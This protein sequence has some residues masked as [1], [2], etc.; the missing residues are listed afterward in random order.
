MKRKKFPIWIII[1]ILLLLV[2]TG[3]MLVV[4]N[5]KEKKKNTGDVVVKD[6]V[7][8][9]TEDDD[10]EDALSDVS[11]NQLVFSRNP[12]YKKGDIIV[13]GIIDEAEDGFIR[14]VIDIEK[15]GGKYIIETEPAVLTDVFEKAHIV[16]KFRLTENGIEEDDTNEPQD[17]ATKN[18]DEFQKVSYDKTN[19]GTKYSI[20]NLSDTEG[21]K[22]EEKHYLG[23]SFNTSFEENINDITTISGETGFNIGLELKLDINHEEVVF[24]IVAKNEFGSTLQLDFSEEMKAEIE[25]VVLEKKLPRYQFEVGGIPIVLSNRIE[26]VVG[27][28]AEMEGYMGIRFDASSENAY[29]FIYDSRKGKVSEIK[30]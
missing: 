14:R 2:I 19:A 21:S 8:A 28:G 22:D 9:I 25:R 4:R 13:A 26:A 10:L 29:G 20:I 12:K 11:E 3:G 18:S 24:G 1:I 23:A 17:R 7:Y 30:E 6:N 16:K 5:M 27:A 15:E